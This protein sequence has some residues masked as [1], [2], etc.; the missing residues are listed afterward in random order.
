[1]KGNDK[2]DVQAALDFLYQRNGQSSI[3]PYGRLC[4]SAAAAEP[5]LEFVHKFNMKGVL[6]DC[7]YHLSMQAQKNDGNTLFK[8]LKTAVAWASLADRCDFGNLLAH[9]EHYMIKHATAAFWNSPAFD[10]H[11][12]SP[13]SLLRLLHAVQTH[14][15][16]CRS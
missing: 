3:D 16:A 12:L 6:K 15:E 5:I 1:M 8:D 14:K 13:G 2:A 4:A 7:D 10:I 9:A 11:P